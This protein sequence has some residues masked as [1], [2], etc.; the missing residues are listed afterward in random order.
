MPSL[1]HLAGAVVAGAAI[2]AFPGQAAAKGVFTSVRV[3]GPSACARIADRAD[4]AAITRAL[5]RSGPAFPR[6]GPYLRVATRPALWDDHG[7]LVPGQGIVQLAGVDHRLGARTAASLRRQVARIAPYRPRVAGVWVLGHREPRPG[8]IAAAMRSRPIA[9]PAG[10]WSSH[11]RLVGV[12]VAGATPWSGWGS[13]L[14]FPALRV[15]YSPDGA[16]VRVTPAQARALGPVPAGSGS[17]G[18]GGVPVAPIV[19]AGAALLAAGGLA[20][21]GAH[22]RQASRS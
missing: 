3:C 20:A 13:A 7:F 9:E 4:R 10:V 8:R 19:L 17:G 12:V 6:L 14:Y 15:L 21:R 5:A 18:G 1:R 16:W 22:G 11:S 2:L